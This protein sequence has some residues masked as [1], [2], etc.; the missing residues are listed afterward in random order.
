METVS[1]TKEQL[2]LIAGCQAFVDV[3]KRSSEEQFHYQPDG[4]WSVA[5]VIQHLYLSARPLVKLMSG[6]RDVLL[7]WGKADAPSRAYEELATTYV[8]ILATGVKAPAAFTPRPEDMNADKNAILERFTQEYQ[9]LIKLIGTWSEL[10][11]DTYMVPHPA[12]GKLTV[13]EMLHFTSAHTHHHL[14]LLPKF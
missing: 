3:T 5:D 11:L 1:L 13:R 2:R 4:K 9:T 14:R 6:P 8:Q 10:D 12:F 7:Q